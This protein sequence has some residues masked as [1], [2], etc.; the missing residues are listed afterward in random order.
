M[1]YACENTDPA[2][3]QKSWGDQWIWYSSSYR[4]NSTTNIS[5]IYNWYIFYA[6]LSIFCSMISLFDCANAV[7]CQ[8]KLKKLRSLHGMFQSVTRSQLCQY[9]SIQL[10]L[11]L[12][13]GF[14]V[15]LPLLSYKQ[16]H[17]VLRADL[18][19]V[20]AVSVFDHFVFLNINTS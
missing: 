2:G 20:A 5:L 15:Y 6:G 18:A 19:G 4:Y 11:A 12:I 9:L 7:T 10:L 13:T 16:A 17:W 3:A 8:K 1:F 14:T